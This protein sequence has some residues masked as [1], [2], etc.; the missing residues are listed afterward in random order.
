MQG[1]GTIISMIQSK[2]A[3]VTRSGAVFSQEFACQRAQIIIFHGHTPDL[4]FGGCQYQT[5]AAGVH[6]PAVNKT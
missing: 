4:E 5:L 6:T 1:H 2:V 3:N